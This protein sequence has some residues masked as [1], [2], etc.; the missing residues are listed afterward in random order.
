[1]RITLEIKCPTC[2][3]DSIKK[4]GIKVDG[5]QNYQ[6]KDCKRQFIGDH[7]LSYLGCNSGITRKILQL[8]VRGSGI[9]DIAEVERISIG[10]VLRTL[11]ESTYQIQPKQSHYESLEVDEFWTFVGN[12]N[13]KQWLIY[14]YHRET[15]EIVAYVWGKRDLATVQRLKTKL[16]QLG[17]HYTRIASDHWDSF[18]TAFKNCKQ[19]IGKFFTVG[20]EGNN[21]KI[22]HRIRR[23]FRRSCNFSKKI[24]NHF[25]AFDLTFFTSI[26]ASFNVSILFE[27]PPI[28]LLLYLIFRQVQDAVLIMA[29]LPFALIGGIWAMYLSGFH[30]SVAI[31][32][33]FIALAGVAAEFGVVMLFYLKQAVEHAQQNLSSSTTSLTEQQL[34]DAIRTGAVLRVRPKAM[35]VAVI[36]AGLIPILLGTG[37]G[38]ELM[39]R[40]ALPMVGGMISAP[41]LS[42][43]VIPAVYQLLIKRKLSTH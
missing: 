24:E 38:S 29:T 41:L 17:I 23:G 32:V 19:S 28:F 8:M 14:A 2:L 39:S 3:S 4:N 13:N 1:M 25:K 26:M 15:G 34:N 11:T 31:A 9:R 37:T 10:K 30:F 40:I 7:A 12:K 22:R 35:T 36:L 33:G 42:M 21:C 5:K 18:I 20:I 16:K 6:C 43:F 27:T